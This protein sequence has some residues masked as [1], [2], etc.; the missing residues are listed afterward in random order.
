MENIP[1]DRLTVQRFQNVSSVM[2]WGAVSKKGKLPL[3]FI[4]KGVRI[5][6]EYYLNNIL[7]NHMLPHAKQLYGNNEFCFQQD[8]A[9][10][11]SA[12]IV[13]RWC[14]DNLPDFI[15]AEEWPP[16]SPDVNPLDFSIWGY[17]L[18]KLGNLKNVNL[19]KFKKILTKLWNEIPDEMVHAAC[20]SFADRLKLVCKRQ[21]ERI[22]IC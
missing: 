1:R 10:A 4:D 19:E 5:N 22:E 8:S 18:S 6:S 13:Q 20:D 3:L 21:G 11:H 12:R 7:I 14:Q 16:S 2:V 9:P 17:M 15:S